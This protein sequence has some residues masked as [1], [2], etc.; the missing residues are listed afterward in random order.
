[1][2][3][4]AGETELTVKI[5]FLSQPWHLF[6]A[7]VTRCVLA[8]AAAGG[9]E[10]GLNALG[11][12]FENREDFVCTDHC[13]GP[14]LNRSPA[15]VVNHVANLS[16]MDFSAAFEQ[17]EVTDAVKWHAKYTRQNGVHVSPTFAVNGL[18]NHSMS[19]GQSIEEWMELL[20][21]K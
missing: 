15:D 11:K 3:A 9:Q 21:L 5:R 18:L 17:D 19:S 10:A 20:G 2:V 6:S 13:S 12:V 16:G 14:N 4:A 7:V 8:A 1:M